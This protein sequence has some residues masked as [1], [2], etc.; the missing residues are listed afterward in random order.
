MPSAMAAIYLIFGFLRMGTSGLVAQARG[1]GDAKETG[2]LLMRALL[3]AFAGGI[4]CVLFQRGIFAGAFYFD[5]VSVAVEGLAKDYMA[6]RIWGAPATIA[7]FAI[8]GWLIAMERTR[9]LLL[10]QIWINGVNAGLDILFVLGWGWGIEGVAS[11]TLIAD[12]SGLALGLYFC[13]SAFLGDQWRDWARVLDPAKLKRMAAV[14]G[15]IMARSIMLEAAFLSFLLFGGR[16]GDVAMAANQILLQ[17]L[18][19]TAYALD[20]FAFAAEV[21][22][23][24]AFGAGNLRNLRRSVYLTSIWGL[25][26]VFALAA[27]FLLL[28]PWVIDVMARNEEVQVAANSY[29]FWMVMAPIMGVAA[30]MLDGVFIGAT[31]TRDMRNGAFVSLIIFGIAVLL[32]TPALGNHG[33]WCALM[34]FFLAR[35]VTLGIRYPAL[36]RAAISG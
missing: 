9:A 7:S 19:I 32:L 2:A 22:V 17:F 31:R 13:R 12:W 10:L 28:G 6:I 8:S 20:G 33:L 27:G 35:G 36:E 24:Q 21:L 26:A 4:A 11:A 25:G 29:L 14:N 30:W 1:A 15:D 18:H 23:G 5:P 16:F 3:I 34:I